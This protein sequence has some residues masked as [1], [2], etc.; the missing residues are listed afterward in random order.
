VKSC[1]GRIWNFVVEVQEGEWKWERQREREVRGAGLGRGFLGQRLWAIVRDS[2]RFDH[3]ETLF[4]VRSGDERV[5]GGDKEVSA[6]PRKS[7]NR[8]DEWLCGK[9]RN[10]DRVVE[11]L[12]A[13]EIEC[14]SP[15]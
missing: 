10:W 9:R 15:S 12:S 13:S 8:L 7:M 14:G 11:G 1:E 3:F 2:E 5:S 6:E 4:G